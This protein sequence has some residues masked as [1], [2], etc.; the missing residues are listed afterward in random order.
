MGVEARGFGRAFGVQGRKGAM[1]SVALHRFELCGF[2]GIPHPIF[3]SPQSSPSSWVLLLHCTLFSSLRGKKSNIIKGYG[4]AQCWGAMF[5][6]PHIAPQNPTLRPLVSW[7]GAQCD[8][9]PQ[10]CAPSHVKVGAQSRPHCA[11]RTAHR[12]SRCRRRATAVRSRQPFPRR[13]HRAL[14]TRCSGMHPSP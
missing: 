3:Y 6:G 1:F 5:F 14:G 9:A 2:W 12:R 13:H 7:C 10:H 11:P 8:F 4:G